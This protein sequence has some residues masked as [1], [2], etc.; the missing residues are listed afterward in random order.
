MLFNIYAS[1]TRCHN[2]ENISD[3]I[4][5]KIYYK[6]IYNTILFRYLR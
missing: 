2:L 3:I 1:R 5:L 6:I 4:E